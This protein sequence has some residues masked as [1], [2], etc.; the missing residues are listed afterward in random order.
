MLYNYSTTDWFQEKCGTSYT[1]IGKEIGTPLLDGKSEAQ[2]E[3]YDNTRKKFILSFNTKL[4]NSGSPL[5]QDNYN[6]VTNNE[7]FSLIL[8]DNGKN[9]YATYSFYYNDLINIKG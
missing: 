5:S 7:Y 9:I 3:I 8:Y 2:I 6:I 4:D 1:V